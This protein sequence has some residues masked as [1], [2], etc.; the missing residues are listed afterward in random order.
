MHESFSLG[1]LSYSIEST[2]LES[3]P[4]QISALRPSRPERVYLIVSYR[5]TNEGRTSI[6]VGLP[7]FELRTA[8]GRRFQPDPIASLLHPAERAEQSGSL[9]AMADV[10]N[11]ELH[12]GLSGAYEVAFRLPTDA[13][14]QRLYLIARRRWLGLGEITVSLN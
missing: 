10:L 4:P 9:G 12:P 7:P 13:S 11:T 1:D 14:R 6:E 2:K 3:Q 5:L 8:D